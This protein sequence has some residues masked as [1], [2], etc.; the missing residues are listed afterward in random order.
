MKLIPSLSFC[1]LLLYHASALGQS[2]TLKPGFDKQECLELLILSAHHA[3]TSFH[4]KLPKQ[5]NFHSVYRSKETGL[6][7]CWDLWTNEKHQAVINVRGSTRDRASWMANFYSAMVAA[8][9]E[10]KLSKTETFTYE[11][12]SDPKAAVHAG[13]LLSVAFLSKDILPK[14]DSIYKTGIKNIFIAGH[15]QGGGVSYLLTAHLYSLQKQGKLPADLRFKTYCTA[16]PKPGN[17]YFA[18]SYEALTQEG[19]AY[20]VVNTAD[21]VPEVPFSVQTVYDFNTV[22]PFSGAKKLV[23]KQKGGKKLLLKHVYKQLSKHPL[24]AQK[25]YE[26]FL[27]H[28]LYKGIKKQLP[29]LEE[30]VYVHTSNYVRTGH[31]IVLQVDEAYYEK[32]PNKQDKVFSHHFFYQYYYLIEKLKPVN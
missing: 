12:S 4:R 31:T 19:W 23:K 15:S 20:T 30:P 6:Q 11:L 29:D 2:T 1:L 16:A 8:K 32:F 14:I 22:N 3:D 17:L 10:L 27:G 9:G 21:W 18:Y 24:K 28:Y 26:K 13:Y 25:K 7:F 5:E